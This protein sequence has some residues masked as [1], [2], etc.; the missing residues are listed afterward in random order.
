MP[1]SVQESRRSEESRLAQ[2]VAAGSTCS[3]QGWPAARCSARNE[4][5]DTRAVVV[6]G[7]QWGDEGKGKLVDILSASAD[8]CARFNG[9]HNAGHTLMVDGAKYSMHLLPCGI[10]H[11]H[12][13][14]VIGNGVVIHLKSLLDELESIKTVQPNALK[15][16]LISS[17]A[18]LL[19]DIHQLVDGLQEETKAKSGRAIGTTLRGIGPCYASKASRIGVRAGD[20]LNIEIFEMKYVRLVHEL[21][22]RYGI[23]F[24][25]ADELRRHRHYAALLREQIVDTTWAVHKALREGKRVLV[26]G[27][28]AA[29]L[30]LDFGTY[31]YV[32][33]SSA[34]VG[35]VCTGLGLP[36]RSIGL[37]VGVVKAYTTRVGEGPFPT[38]LCGPIGAHLREKGAEYGT[39]TGR[40]RRCGWIDVPAL[41]YAARINSF[42]CLNLTKLDVLTGLEEIKI[43]V[44]Y[45][46][47]EKQECMP[48]YYFPSTV[49]EYAYLDPVYETM[50]GW[51][52]NLESCKTLRELPAAAQAYVAR[53]EQLL[54]LPC[55]WIGVGPDRSHTLTTSL[56][57][58]AIVQV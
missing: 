22:Q 20:L 42:D 32:T 28:N 7:A 11:D 10:L 12:S 56:P 49:E 39:T 2:K 53:L 36:P 48:F 33:S 23:A 15:R 55:C 34:T 43:C 18:H 54:S 27:A 16:L 35:G 38:E 46:D 6:I 9:G 30:D 19:F 24:D 8:M 57:G 47:R 40:P 37:C 45:R 50:A 17:R 13:L 3:L 58:E 14:N 41:L 1:N 29:L 52:Q 44:A 21:K 5:G 51:T 31:P 26:E 25:E 4:E